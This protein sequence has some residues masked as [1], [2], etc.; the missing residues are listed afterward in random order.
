[1]LMI[2]LLEIAKLIEKNYE[3]FRLVTPGLDSD[4]MHSF[5]IDL[6]S[7]KEVS[8]LADKLKGESFH[9][10]IHLAFILCKPGDW[11]N[12]TYLHKNNQITEKQVNGSEL[13]LFKKQLILMIQ[14]WLFLLMVKMNKCVLMLRVM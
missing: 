8:T 11:D 4:D 13:R 7:K 1:M 5:S 9:A 12:F 6:T 10:V 14:E 3:I 2:K